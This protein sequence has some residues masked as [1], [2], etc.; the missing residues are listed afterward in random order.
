M[1]IILIHKIHCKL[2]YNWEAKRVLQ[3]SDIDVVDLLKIDG[4]WSEYEILLSCTND[5]LK[6]INY[7]IMEQHITPKTE[8]H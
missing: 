7:I 6:R 5:I 8:L 2:K 3:E 1:H 4:E